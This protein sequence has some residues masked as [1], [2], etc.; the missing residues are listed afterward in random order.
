MTKLVRNL[1]HPAD[2][3]APPSVAD[4]ARWPAA[5]VAARPAR[6]GGKS[7]LPLPPALRLTLVGLVVVVGLAGCAGT[8]TS[9]TATPSAGASA[10]ATPTTSVAPTPSVTPTSSPVP[11]TPAPLTF[12]ATGSMHTA[13]SRAT[14]TLLKN[15]Q[16]LIAGGALDYGGTQDV[17]ASAELYDPATGKFSPTGSMTAARSYATATLL[18]DGRVLIAGG[19]GCSNRRSCYV[20]NDSTQHLT[21]AELYDPATSKFT[22]TGSMTGSRSYA[23]SAL[24]PGG[25]VFLAGGDKWAELYDPSSGKFARTGKPTVQSGYNTVTLLPSG[26]VLVTEQSASLD[27]FAQ[28][29][30]VASGTFT[31][32]SLA[33][34]PGTPTVHYGGFVLMRAA[35]STA[36]LLKDGRVLLFEGGYLETYDPATGACIDA[37]FISPAGQWDGATATL[38][39]D[40]RVLYEGGYLNNSD[41]TN[42]AVLYDP[43]GGPSRT[44]STQAARSSQTATLLPDGSVLIAG[45]DGT[46]ADGNPVASAELFKP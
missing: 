9:P 24:L 34:P 27:T 46:N 8:P 19:D 35:P 39:P 20:A 21:S 11:T 13:R 7:R 6:L 17:Y 25:R 43:T 2:F 41:P 26:K 32:I 10:D 3:E 12:V 15:G 31:T 38:M 4:R 44:G 5:D 18:T 1:P 42:I 28:L 40:G 45:G 30:D 36:T 16:V 33:L 22:A 23:A 29:Y 37:G 14:A